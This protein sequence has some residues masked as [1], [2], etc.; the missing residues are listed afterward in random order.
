MKIIVTSLDARSISPRRNVVD[1]CLMPCLVNRVCLYKVYLEEE[2][3]KH[4]RIWTSGPS[5][6][7]IFAR[8]TKLMVADDSFCT[9]MYLCHITVPF[10][11]KTSPCNKHPLTPHFYIRLSQDQ[12]QIFVSSE[13]IFQGCLSD[14]ILCFLKSTNEAVSENVYIGYNIL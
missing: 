9:S 10:I 1:F 11:T 12:M 14:F 5:V 4:H 8:T 3:Y 6:S 2:E 7:L 13:V